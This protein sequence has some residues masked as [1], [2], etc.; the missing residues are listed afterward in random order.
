MGIDIYVM[1]KLNLSRESSLILFSHSASL[2]SNQSPHPKDF[3]SYGFLKSACSSPSLQL[4]NS[5]DSFYTIFINSPSVAALIIYCCVINYPKT[6]KFKTTIN[7]ISL[8]QETSKYFCCCCHCLR[9]PLGSE[10]PLPLASMLSPT[11]IFLP[12]LYSTHL[13]R[14]ISRVILPRKSMLSLSSNS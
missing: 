7:R 9:L 8:V 6:Y 14:L 12:K 10:C 13:S 4:P 5:S 3:N 1:P 11:F 2:P